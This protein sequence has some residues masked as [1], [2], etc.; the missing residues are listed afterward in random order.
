MLFNK[1]RNRNW[2]V[3]MFEEKF[4][5]AIYV[6]FARFNWWKM[7]KMKVKRQNSGRCYKLEEWKIKDWLCM[8]SKECWIFNSIKDIS[9]YTTEVIAFL[10]TVPGIFPKFWMGFL[11]LLILETKFLGIW[12]NIYWKFQLY[13]T[14]ISM[15][16]SIIHR[17]QFQSNHMLQGSIFRKLLSLHAS[18]SI[19][20]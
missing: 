17:L 19:F 14:R 12:E 6:A 5:C 18:T 4:W 9:L 10:S 16:V 15:K 13:S 20:P 2:I 7:M 8:K 1:I 11:W 3:K